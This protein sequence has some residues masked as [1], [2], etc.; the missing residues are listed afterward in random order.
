MQRR[1]GVYAACVAIIVLS[2]FF[3]FAQAV[4]S[5]SDIQKAIDEHNAAID[6]LNKDIAN[7]QKQLDTVSTKK[8]TL[9]STLDQLNLSLKK[10]TASVN[11]TKN[12]ISATQLEIQQLTSGI[13]D[14]QTSIET[15]EAGLAESI[16]ILANSE[17]QPLAVQLLSSDTV[18]TAWEDIDA[19][20]SV[21]RAV[22]DRITKLSSE[23]QSL[24]DTKKAT[25]DKKAQLV[26]QQNEL[27]TQQGSLNATKKAQS[28][29]LSQTKAQESNFQ[30][31]IA[32]KKAQEASFESAL[33]DL[34]AKLKIAINPSQI[35]PAGKGILAWPLDV[36]R[37][38]QY[39]GNTPFAQTGAYNGKGHNGI[40]LAASIGTPVK[41]ALSGTILGTG[42]TDAVRGC[43][44]FGKWVM[45]KHANGLNTMYAH[46]S[47][48]NV[49]QGQ[50][51][52]TGD[53]LGYSGETG[54][55]TGPHLHFGVYVSSATQIIKLGQA[56]NSSTPCANAV[57]PVAPL[58]G[59]L[60]P[61]NY[62]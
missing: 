11:V 45:I 6:Q 62:L 5:A 57:M 13:A 3:V 48:I 16:R 43:Y 34:Q 18:S 53:V 22:H 24:V 19:T 39:F 32:Q 1:T 50:A 23:K 37:I 56:T 7:Y 8:Q 25:E 38:T 42:N 44:S 28:D 20:E 30:A 41:A 4:G 54:Y 2:P 59:Y 49:S 52:S 36:V 27:V 29:L 46:L 61:L 58:E 33:T 31:I 51:V 35:T 12:K 60:N 9:Q 40:D 47:Q 55:A 15:D 21:Q 10:I 26:E 17:M 14:K